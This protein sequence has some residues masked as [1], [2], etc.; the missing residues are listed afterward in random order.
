MGL[1]YISQPQ[2]FLQPITAIGG[3]QNGIY[4]SVLPPLYT[5]FYTWTSTFQ[6]SST[7][8][9]LTGITTLTNKP[10]SF[11]VT[12]GGVLQSPT[13]YT[14]SI[15]GRTL[16]FDTPV[17]PDTEV[18]VT[19]IGTIATSALDI[20]FL[21]AAN[22]VFNNSVF[23][24]V[25]AT[26][27]YVLSSVRGNNIVVDN[28]LLTNV[29]ATNLRVLASTFLGGTLFDSV[30][31][32]SLTVLSAIINQQN[33]VV[34]LASATS[35][36]AINTSLFLGPISATSNLTVN[37]SS[38]FTDNIS[39][40]GIANFT[41]INTNNISAVNI[42]GNVLATNSLSARSLQNRFGDII[43]VKDFGARGDGFSNDTLAI[44]AALIAGGNEA[45]YVPTGIYKIDS[46]ITIPNTIVRIQGDGDLSIL[47]FSNGGRINFISTL[48]QLPN[49][50]TNLSAGDNSLIFNSTHNL[51]EEDA[52]ILYNP[53]N[54]SFAPMRYY[55]RDGHMFRVSQLTSSTG[56]KTYGN[57]LSTFTAA[58]LS[59]YK[60]NGGSVSL[61]NFKIIPP[62]VDNG[63]PVIN[64]EHHQGVK[65]SN[66]SFT[67][68][69]AGSG[70]QITRCFDTI[71]DN[72][73][74]E[75]FGT[76]DDYPIIM[77][78]CQQFRVSNCTLYS[79]WHAI[80]LGG[81][82]KV[83]CVPCRSGIISNCHLMNDSTI[84][85]GA[86]DIHGNCDNIQ[87]EN[88]YIDT[89]ADMAGSNVS[90]IDCTILGRNPAY[91]NDGICIFGSSE[92]LKGTYRIENCRLIT[93]GNGS[94]Y[95]IINIY[96]QRITGDLNVN[97][98]NCTIEN[99]GVTSSSMRS[100]MVVT[101]AVG[102]NY[103]I[104]IDG[105]NVYSP[106]AFA[107]LAVT[108][109]DDVSNNLTVSVN[110]VYGP[111]G[112][113][114]YIASNTN[115]LNAPMRMQ[116]Q[117]G[118]QSLSTVTNSNLVLGSTQTFRYPYP[119]VPSAQCTAV[120]SYSG[121]L[122]AYASFNDIT[123]TT[124]RPLLTNGT[125]STNWSI[126]GARPVYWT[127]QINEI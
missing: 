105:L 48:T 11:I 93:T 122:M 7:V 113:D 39:V 117:T 20:T 54:F 118:T 108:G 34:T 89:V 125:T 17:N 97:I 30:T 82:D 123:S 10:G 127:A 71:I 6:V 70:I 55:Y 126:V 26:N 3:I 4:G 52:I 16:T 109:P 98:K 114:L 53:T 5:S 13:T 51:L 35:L 115:N 85:V 42:A 81:D 57:S 65:L 63:F 107:F 45:V 61:S 103:N 32:V 28:S 8:F 95:G 86:A 19:Q 116:Q 99:K 87:Y 111:A 40:S 36:T 77:A 80:A 72:C 90:Y 31:A 101:S 83:C 18:L 96:G 41:T 66:L 21:S 23:N 100:V 44:S 76:G 38:V 15:S 94:S 25:S 46:P 75:V 33:T 2:V 104:N 68:K 110:N 1:E 27:L 43:N 12:V 79:S 84:G 92:V 74:A 119:R 50:T 62:T 67:R 58:S 102:F 9:P 124:I 120:G 60:I 69:S 106:D 64:V 14:I 73:N 121:N 78:N 47:D 29:T 37:G 22:S 112:T 49:L 56:V 88:C 91:W 59:C 24:N